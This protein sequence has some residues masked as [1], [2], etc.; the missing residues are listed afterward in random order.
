MFSSYIGCPHPNVLDH[1]HTRRHPSEREMIW[2]NP[3]AIPDGAGDTR[4]GALHAGGAS[5]L[6]SVAT[7]HCLVSGAQLRA[8][9]A[10]MVALG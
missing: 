7:S 3:T 9:T 1:S 10:F 8:P 5:W 2:R 6:P 4:D